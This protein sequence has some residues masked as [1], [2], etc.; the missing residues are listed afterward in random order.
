MPS[1]I[2][3]ICII[4]GVILLI[5]GPISVDI[6]YFNQIVGIALIIGGPVLAKKL[7]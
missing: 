2:S 3:A 6:Q 1:I 4:L 5:F 7:G